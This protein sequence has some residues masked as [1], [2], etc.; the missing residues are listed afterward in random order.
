[1]HT[2]A[3][4]HRLTLG[5]FRWLAV[6]EARRLLF[7]ARDDE[8]LA[9][10]GGFVKRNPA[11]LL[12]D[13][14][15][16]DILAVIRTETDPIVQQYPKIAEIVNKTEE[17]A[18]EIAVALVPAQNVANDLL[19][20]YH[21][22]LVLHG[23]GP[24]GDAGLTVRA[25]DDTIVVTAQ[26][27]RADSD[28]VPAAVLEL[29]AEDRAFMAAICNRISR[30]RHARR[31]LTL[32]ETTAVLT[33]YHLLEQGVQVP[34][35]FK[36]IGVFGFRR[37]Q[38]NLSLADPGEGHIQVTCADAELLTGVV[39]HI[40]HIDRDKEADRE[41]VE[42]YRLPAHR[43]AARVRLH[44]GATA[45]C[46]AFIGRPVFE[47]RQ[48][49]VD[50]LKTVHM[51]ASACTAMFI[52]G[53]ADCKIGIERMTAKEAITFMRAVAGNVARD[54]SRQYLSAAFNINVPL[55]DDRGEVATTLTDAY[56]IGLAG[57]ELAV[58][59]RFEKV[60]WDGASNKVPSDPIVTQ[61]PF[62]K[63]IELVH[64]AHE[65]GLETYISAG[66]LPLHMRECVFLGVDGVG[67]GTSLHYVDPATKL[68][69]QLKPEIIREV[70]RI[71]D[72]A[73]AEPL[74]LAA[75]RLA[76]LDR[77][78]FEKTLPAALD[79][80]RSVL[81]EALRARNQVAATTALAAV[82]AA[83]LP[84]F[85]SD[86]PVIAHARRVLATAEQDP[87]AARAMTGDEWRDYVGT[88][89]TLLRNRDIAE[90]RRLLK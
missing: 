90:L 69:G 59:G 39:V 20:L 85:D 68:M 26:S 48:F 61:I 64:I 62:E 63:L 10:G 8:E 84:A 51:T 56:G 12:T 40:E 7:K 72:A 25:A 29:D 82:G 88:I 3:V 19:N 47:S 6:S 77:M 41:K 37:H 1:M 54:Q 42:P 43:N 23:V 75:E 5:A 71:R 74:G 30:A 28:G 79:P 34:T 16:A 87:L 22:L 55:I 50:L 38:T 9:A 2:K 33:A 66:L 80:L 57:I 24:G 78:Y 21:R 31:P 32:E 27:Q 70:L 15:I 14:T 49:N 36:G 73:A 60:A 76:K 89:A 81:F 11:P 46:T 53:V 13:E 83:D 65:N 52:N 4:E 35:A 45:P 18:G 17:I 44:T 86:H 58:Q 67:I